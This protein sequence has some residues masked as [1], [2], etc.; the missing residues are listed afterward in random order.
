ME[1]N[2]LKLKSAKRMNHTYNTNYVTNVLHTHS[3]SI[4]YITDAYTFTQYRT[5]YVIDAH[6]HSPP[7]LRHSSTHTGAHTMNTRSHTIT[8]HPSQPSTTQHNITL[9]LSCV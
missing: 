5:S 4:G 3:T 7:Y 8:P 2:N 6:T 9:L 1:K